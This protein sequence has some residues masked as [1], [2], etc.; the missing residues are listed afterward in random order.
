MYKYIFKTFYSKFILVLFSI[1]IAAIPTVLVNFFANTCFNV[2]KIYNKYFDDH[3][4]YKQLTILDGNLTNSDSYSSRRLQK[5]QASLI[6]FNEIQIE[7]YEIAYTDST[8]FILKSDSE[9]GFEIYGSSELQTDSAIISYSFAKY[10][11]D[12]PNNLISKE[13]EIIIDGKS[14][15]FIITGVTSEKFAEV[16]NENMYPDIILFEANLKETN[17]ITYEANSIYEVKSLKSKLN[18]GFII[19]HSETIQNIISSAKVVMAILIIIAIAFSL[20]T[21]LVVKIFHGFIISEKT[22]H[23]KMLNILGLTRMKLNKILAVYIII[24]SI[25]LFSV[26]TLFLLAFSS[27]LNMIIDWTLLLGASY[28]FISFNFWGSITT[29]LIITTVNLIG[30]FFIAKNISELDISN[31]RIVDEGL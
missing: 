9:S 4:Y 22:T 24:Y 12:E 11:S 29:L 28:N 25:A 19:D 30:T 16:L 3:S 8:S 10:F 21:I 23:F 7:N 6:N 18:S 1:L 5:L 14:D 13:I 27:Y 31:L 2:P 17:I 15:N 20:L 26:S